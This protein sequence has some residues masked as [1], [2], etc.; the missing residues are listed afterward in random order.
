MHYPKRGEIMEKLTEQEVVRRE[1]LEFLKDKGL[2]PFGQR[3]D[4][5]HNTNTLKEAFDKYSKEELHDMEQDQVKIAGR[6]MTKRG[7]GKAGFAHIMDQHGQVQLYVRLDAVGE[8]AFEVWNKA[9][10]GDIVGVS[11]SVMKT[12]MGELSVR[13]EQLTHLSKAIRPLPEKWHGLQ[14]IEERYRRRYVD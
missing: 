8:E 7:K 2:D 14:D 11:G 12:K 1:K 4:R 10:L 9:D 5:T 6:I 3:F 13:A